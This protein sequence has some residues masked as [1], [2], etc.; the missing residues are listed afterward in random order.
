M[1]IKATEQLK[2]QRLFYSSDII[3]YVIVAVLIV[4]LFWVFVFTKPVIN[5]SKVNFVYSDGIEG[6]RVIF[7]YDFT[8]EKYVIAEGIWTDLIEV[9]EQ[10]FGYLVKVGYPTAKTVEYN[11]VKID[12]SGSVSVIDADCSF[13]KDCVK[14]PPITDG[15]GVIICVPHKLTIETEGSGDVG[16]DIILG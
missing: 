5:L 1:S 13:H 16:G 10:D 8:T 14:F 11:L 6:E 3:I 9:T 2:K 4:A 12:K 7:S 15:S